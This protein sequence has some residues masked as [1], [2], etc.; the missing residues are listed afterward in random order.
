MESTKHKCSPNRLEADGTCFTKDEIICIFRAF[1]SM[2]SLSE[3]SDADVEK[4]TKKVL[5]KDLNNALKEFVDLKGASWL[6]NPE[7]IER[8]QQICPALAEA[9]CFYALRPAFTGNPEKQWLNEMDL[10]VIMA[11]YADYIPTLHYEGTF[12]ADSF[13]DQLTMEAPNT[14]FFRSASNRHR[15]WSMIINTAWAEV[16][17][18]HWVAVCQTYNGPLEYFDPEGDDIA[19]SLDP[20]I[21]WMA[22][23]S[24][25]RRNTLRHQYDEYMCGPYS[26]F[27]ICNRAQCVKFDKFNTHP[28]DYSVISDFRRLSFQ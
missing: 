11:Q 5:W 4:K 27:F 10:N 28:I 7:F 12:T 26:C 8:V 16:G 20:T 3:W 22:S 13:L 6:M 19:T 18:E 17:G 1:K 23:T 14:L 25:I 9:I 15:V 24:G 2:F 21:R